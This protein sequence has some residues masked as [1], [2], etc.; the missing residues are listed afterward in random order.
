M[1]A[2]LTIIDDVGPGTPLRS[3]GLEIPG[4]T[5]TLRDVIRSRVREEV[6]RFNL[7]SEDVFCGLVQPSGS[8]PTRDGYRL[9]QPR[10]L[11]WL[12]Q[13]QR[14]IVGFEQNGFF[15]VVDNKQVDDLDQPIPLSERTEVH[16]LKLVPLIG[17]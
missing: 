5:V 14:A 7:R 2:T 1:A 8:Q 12:E 16:F 6:E 3:F 15:V 13:Y 11:D 4:T 10:P 17:G 9:L